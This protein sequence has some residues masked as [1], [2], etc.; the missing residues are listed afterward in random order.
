[1]GHAS[2]KQGHGLERLESRVWDLE[3]VKYRSCHDSRA[4]CLRF[5]KFGHAS[6]H[7]VGQM[8][9]SVPK[10]CRRFW[11]AATFLESVGLRFSGGNT[12]LKL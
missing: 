9:P 7:V 10:F 11:A 2:G 4:L 12:T 5:T 3:G 8:L 6:P 1:M